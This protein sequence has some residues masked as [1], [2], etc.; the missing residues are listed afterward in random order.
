MKTEYQEGDL[1]TI[2]NARIEKNLGIVISV[3]RNFYR[4]RTGEVALDRIAVLWA[5]DG[6]LSYEPSSFIEL[7]ANKNQE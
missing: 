3:E 4:N 5:L 2:K 7:F 1:V 6:E